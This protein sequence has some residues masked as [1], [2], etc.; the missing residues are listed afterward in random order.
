MLKKK[1]TTAEEL[2]KTFPDEFKSFLLYSKSLK[3]EETPD[4]AYLRRLFKNLFSQSDFTY[5]YSFDWT[6]C[7]HPACEWQNKHTEHKENEEKK[8]EIHEEKKIEPQ[9]EKKVN[10]TIFLESQ[11][12]PIP[13]LE[14]NHTIVKTQE[15]P[16]KNCVLF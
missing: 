10:E 14:V 13:T 16:K 9:E 5:D 2:C 11:N 1:T 7:N 12:T 6:L 8:A 3:F 4:Y 15:K